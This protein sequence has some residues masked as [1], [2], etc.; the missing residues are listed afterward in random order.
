MPRL[1]T[2]D[3]M[4]THKI[5]GG[6]FT[7]SGARISNLGATEYTLATI[8]VDVT[9]SVSGH[10]GELLDML[11][12]SVEACKKSP[13][14]DNLLLRVCTFSSMFKNGVNEIHGFKPLADI[15]IADYPPFRVGGS[16]PLNDACY[17]AIGATNAY[18]KQLVD[19]D[20]LVNAITFD[21][22][23]GEENSSV[24]TPAML[25]QE[26]AKSVSGEILE[27]H[28]SVLIGIN[29][30][31]SSAAMLKQFQQEA[32]ITQFI[33]AGDVN[34]GRLAKLAAFVSHSVSSTSQAL[35][36]GGPSQQI[37]ATI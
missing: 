32:G 9:G 13:R 1:G 4:E 33:D 27:S 3:D 31:G 23:D 34:K 6:N 36:T 7:F 20:F 25:K 21:I 11:T 29:T 19:Q 17:S 22:T 24:S 26:V 30:S 37:A 16:T 10:E 18:G 8:M 5:G 35:G 2:D 15:N 14:S 28:V 12:A